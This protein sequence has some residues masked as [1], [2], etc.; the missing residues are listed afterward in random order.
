[1]KHWKETGELLERAVRLA[2]SGRGAAIATVV[3]IE[4]SAYRR[5]GAKYLVEA[6]GETAG[7]I[8]G[9]CL[10]ADVR[11]IALGIAAGA[12]PRLLRYDTG[13]DDGSP[14]GLGLGCSGA[15]EIFVQRLGSEEL[16]IARAQLELLSGD[17]AFAVGTLLDGPAAGGSVVVSA[18]G[19]RAGSRAQTALDSALAAVAA[20]AL[21]ARESRR[22]RLDGAG[23]D[24]F[25]E[26][27]DP[28]P[29]LVIFGAGDDAMPLCAFSS[30]AGFRVTIVD[31]REATLEASRFPGAW[32]RVLLRPEDGTGSLPLEP[33]TLGVV[34][35]HSFG[36]D[37]E[38]IRLLLAAGVRYAGLL[39]PRARAKEILT[40]IGADEE[41]AGR[42]Y[43][44]VGLD[45][46]AEGPE[47]VALSIVSELLAFHA[48]REPASLR[49]KRNPIHAG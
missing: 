17:A 36:L 22:R 26:V 24:V 10:E 9:G 46:G 11:E 43:A 4:R 1:M 23:A 37:R 2:E 42:V 38:W 16:E 6:G 49:G 25:V 34:K 48:S 41:T 13:G 40:Q 12:A 31:H 29:H 3:A 21:A 33:G 45:L 20:A 39:G 5:P 27:L 44:P 14:F 47:Q 15:I 18:E 7:S 32:R 35:T 8:S 28:P 19:T 30:A